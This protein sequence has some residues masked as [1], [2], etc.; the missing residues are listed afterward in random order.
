M[1]C[2]GWSK[3]KR[4]RLRSELSLLSASL[5]I[6]INCHC[7]SKWYKDGDPSESWSKE[8]AITYRA[9]AKFGPKCRSLEADLAFVRLE[10]Q[11]TT[12][13]QNVKKMNFIH[14]PKERLPITDDHKWGNQ[15]K[16]TITGSVTKDEGKTG[17]F[18]NTWLIREVKTSGKW[19]TGVNNQ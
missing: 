19:D 11:S 2:H 1:G 14:E 18:I 17:Q 4:M 8:T 10:E 12:K 6:L 13:L 3:Q 7:C 5:L 9:S 15:Q 16:T